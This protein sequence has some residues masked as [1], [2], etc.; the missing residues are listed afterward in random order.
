MEEE[1]RKTKLPF[2][3]PNSICWWNYQVYSICVERKEETRDWF[4]LFWSGGQQKTLPSGLDGKLVLNKS[5]F[6]FDGKLVPKIIKQLELETDWDLPFQSQIQI[7]F[8]FIFRLERFWINLQI[9]INIH[10]ISFLRWSFY[11]KKHLRKMKYTQ[12]LNLHFINI[13]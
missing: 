4:I 7:I 5:S 10:H 2:L 8:F 9:L 11:L 13:S 1:R 3:V 12:N 6:S